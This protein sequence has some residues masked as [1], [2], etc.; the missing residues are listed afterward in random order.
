MKT[1]IFVLLLLLAMLLCV[2]CNALYINKVAFEMENRLSDL[3]APPAEDA[4]KEID[5]L[6]AYWERQ[7]PYLSLSVGF[8]LLDRIGEQLR[9]LGVYAENGD[10]FGYTEALTILRD[11][12]RDL[13]RL[14]QCSVENLL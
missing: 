2:L 8:P 13:C 4:K 11:C 10:V 5:M 7:T 6:Q 14:E 12:M 9:L 1:G 3:S